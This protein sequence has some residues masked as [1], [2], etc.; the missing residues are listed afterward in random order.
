MIEQDDSRGS[1]STESYCWTTL[2][3]RLKTRESKRV[4]ASENEEIEETETWMDMV[5]RR[6]SMAEEKQAL[7]TRLSLL[8]DW[9]KLKH[10]VN[11][12]L[13]RIPFLTGAFYAI[14]L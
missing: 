6:R 5:I 14:G 9:N 4:D 10:R 12:Y 7:A 3:D 13:L 8:D 11:N 1:R 2:D